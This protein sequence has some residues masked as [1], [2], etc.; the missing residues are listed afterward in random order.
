MADAG[1]AETEQAGSARVRLMVT[2]NVN[3]DVLMGRLAPWPRAGTEVEVAQYALRVG[4]ALGNTALALTAL[5]AEASY[6]ANVGSDVLGDWLYEELAR[7]GCT[8]ERS[9]GETALTVGISHPGGQRTFLSHLGHFR[10]FDAR[11]VH[12]AA[13]TAAAGSLLL[14]SGYFLLPGLRAEAL[15]LMASARRR[16]VLTLLDTGWPTEGWTEAV[17]EEI[18]GLLPHCDFFL[19]NLEEAEA[20]TGERKV[21]SCLSQ[22]NPHLAGRTIVKLGREGAGFLEHGKLVTVAAPQVEVV[23]TVGAG[24]SFNA[25]F[26]AGLK[27]ARPWQDA[28]TLAVHTASLAI[29]SDPRRYPAWAELEASLTG[30]AAVR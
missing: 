15:D 22:L 18:F 5:G 28:V 29:A 21:A 2:G 3:V 19:P 23:D 4:G 13:T 24:D 17:K 27:R 16:G 7:R 26:L 14:V 10:D 11:A 9:S 1:R 30:D 25:G 6:F 20:L 12:D 8:L